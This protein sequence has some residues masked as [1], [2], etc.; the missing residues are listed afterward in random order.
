MTIQT[1]ETLIYE[2]IEYSM[3]SFVLEQVKPKIEFHP[4][5]SFCWRGY[6]GT[7]EI[8]NNKLYLVDLIAWRRDPNSRRIVPQIRVDEEAEFYMGEREEFDFQELAL[9]DVFPAVSTDGVFA[10]W[11]TGELAIPSKSSDEKGKHANYLVFSLLN[12]VIQSKSI[13]SYKEAFKPF[14][15]DQLIKK[16]QRSINEDF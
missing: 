1:P 4:I 5:G 12:G 3:R 7:W 11:F 13:K 2:G 15:R 10:D 6:R 8:K 14:D 9:Q 16:L